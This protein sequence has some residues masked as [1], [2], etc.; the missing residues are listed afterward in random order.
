MA[1]ALLLPLSV[2]GHAV[3]LLQVQ[4]PTTSSRRRGGLGLQVD[5]AGRLAQL[6]QLLDDEVVAAQGGTGSSGRWQ[7]S[8][9]TA[10]AVVV[11][12]PGVGSSSG[13]EDHAPPAAAAAAGG[14]GSS[15]AEA[16]AGLPC[17]SSGSISA[18]AVAG[19]P[20]EGLLP[21]Q[22]SEQQQQRQQ[23]AG[24]VVCAEAEAT[25]GR[26]GNRRGV[27]VGMWG[28]SVGVGGAARQSVL[29]RCVQAW[30]WAGC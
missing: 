29:D 11:L 15:V 13:A 5:L 18:E 27:D 2:N 8:A 9:R 22:H 24:L 4:A 26:G 7:P 21:Q 25:R 14:S 12:Q 23:Q 3:A 19:L 30:L 20:N 17:S 28:T 16:V 10:A 1:V 6:V